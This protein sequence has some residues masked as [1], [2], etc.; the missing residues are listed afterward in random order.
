MYVEPR[1]SLGCDEIICLC[2][3]TKSGVP[4]LER[5]KRKKRKKRKNI[6]SLG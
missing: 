3:E 5:K 4:K 2:F 6:E 1:E